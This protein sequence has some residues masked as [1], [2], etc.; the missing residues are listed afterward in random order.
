M[1]RFWFAIP[2]VALVFSVF[3]L[4]DTDIWWHLACGRDWVSTWTPVREPVVNVHEFFQ[5]IVYFIYGLGGAPL[6]VALKSLMWGFVIGLFLWPIK[7]RISLFSLFIAGLLFFVFRY[8]MEIRPIVFSLLFL[9]LYWNLVPL[10]FKESTAIRK[11]AVGIMILALQWIW[12]RIQGLYILGPLFVGMFFAVKYIDC[13]NV[14][15]DQQKKEILFGL[16]FVAALFA[17]PFGHGDGL[18]LFLYPF[19]LLDR[20]LGLTQSATIFARE[21]AENR[22]PLTL[23]LQGENVAESLSMIATVLISLWGCWRCLKS[24][25]V[26][27]VCLLTTS[28]LAMVAERNFVLLMPIFLY[29]ICIMKVNE[30]VLPK[31]K[32]ITFVGLFF[33]AGLWVRS[34]MV[35]DLSMISYQRVPVAA[36]EWMKN[37]PHQGHLFNDDRAGGYLAFVNPSDSIYIDGRFILKT[38]EFFQ[39]YLGFTENPEVFMRYADSLGIDRTLFPLR[40]Y[41]RW[42]KV[43]DTLV[44]SNQWIMTYRDEYFCVFQ[45]VY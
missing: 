38:S 3:P 19:G 41:A 29:F 25:K 42:G 5:Q 22:S 2:L 12:C 45:K 20:L 9:G 35:Y 33:I 15:A 27:A 7:N 39:Q 13:R 6:L 31:L 44:E 40:Y 26:L 28:S 4:T 17:M 21:I 24:N 32:W 18:D 36:A 14:S 37:N 34:L 30:N 10:F 23:L 43:I 16:L 11:L 1:S 8:Q